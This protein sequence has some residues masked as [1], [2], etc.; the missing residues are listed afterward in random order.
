MAPKIMGDGV[1]KIVEVRIHL[2]Q[3]FCVKGEM[4]VAFFQQLCYYLQL[5][6]AFCQ[7]AYQRSSLV[8]QIIN[9]LLRVDD[10]GDIRHLMDD[11]THTSLLIEYRRVDG[12]PEF[13]F[14][15]TPLSDRPGHIITLQ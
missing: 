8:F 12:I 3:S 5:L 1:S 11:V 15:T 9:L 6:I 4:L 2:Q 13:L 10:I 7:N 14:K